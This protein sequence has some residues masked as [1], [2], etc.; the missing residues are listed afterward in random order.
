MTVA[1]TTLLN[2]TTVAAAA[3]TDAPEL[4][5]TVGLE[6]IT[7]NTA[8][9]GLQHESKA[10]AFVVDEDVAAGVFT[11]MVTLLVP[12]LETVTATVVVM[13]TVLTTL[14]QLEGTAEASLSLAFATWAVFLLLSADDAGR[15][16]ALLLGV[17]GR[18]ARLEGS[19][20]G[21]ALPEGRL[22][23]DTGDEVR[24]GRVV[25]VATLGRGMGRLTRE[26]VG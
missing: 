14:L 6:L 24:E 8:G 17:G 12:L 19:E 25:T 15:G 16:E 5:A 2:G 10:S 20:L 1:L 22:G 23:T 26:V 11:G 13:G 3:L 4:T 9:A 7:G 21:G 18:A